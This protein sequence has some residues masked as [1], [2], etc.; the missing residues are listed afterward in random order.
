MGVEL[1]QGIGLQR[2]ASEVV[3]VVAEQPDGRQQLQRRAPP[4]HPVAQLP[5]HRHA[6]AA[7]PAVLAEVQQ[8]AAVVLAD[9]QAQIDEQVEREAGLVAQH[10]GNILLGRRA[11]Q[12]DGEFEH[13]IA[14]SARRLVDRPAGHGHVAGN[15]PHLQ[16]H[17][18]HGGA[19]EQL[20]GMG[21]ARQGHAG[22]ELRPGRHGMGGI[23]RIGIAADRVE[24]DRHRIPVGQALQVEARRHLGL[25]FRQAENADDRQECAEQARPLCLVHDSSLKKSSDPADSRPGIAHCFG[26]ATM[27][28]GGTNCRW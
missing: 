7:I 18:R 3:G 14:E 24:D 4:R 21:I 16:D 26:S 6:D 12:V 17:R 10:I 20:E 2:L 9:R 1:E 27:S 13:R 8:P 15:T 28:A 23:E 11:D 25:R 19:I 5:D 22:V